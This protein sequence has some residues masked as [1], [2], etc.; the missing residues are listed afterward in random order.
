MIYFR[1]A[2]IFSLKN[3]KSLKFPKKTVTTLR[4]C[5]KSNY[6]QCC[7]N[8]RT[9]IVFKKQDTRDQIPLDVNQNQIFIGCSRGV[10]RSG[11]EWKLP[12][13]KPDNE[14]TKKLQEY[15]CS[16]LVILPRTRNGVA[17]KQ[18]PEMSSD[19]PKK[20]C[21]LVHLLSILHFQLR[22]RRHPPPLR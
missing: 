22:Q 7:V 5:P 9:R 19:V 14:A 2:L 1:V 20:H 18:H 16:S 17:T 6:G 15:L 13:K 10:K 3:H 11:H 21:E 8:I 12:N 4:I